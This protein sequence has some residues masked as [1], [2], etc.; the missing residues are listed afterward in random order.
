MR[1]LMLTTSASLMDGINRHILAISSGLQARGVEVC[2]C[3]VHSQ[4]DFIAALRNAGVEVCSLGCKNG[5]SLRIPLRFARV[6]N[7]F[8]PD[9]V[10]VHVLAFMERLVLSTLFSRVKVVQT[11]HGISDPVSSRTWRQ[12]VANLLERVFDVRI[13]R[14][15]FVSNGVRRAFGGGADND[16]TIYNPVGIHHS[17]RSTLRQELGVPDSVNIVG[18]ACRIASVKNPL[19]FT[20]VIREVTKRITGS[21]GVV[22]GD[23]DPVLMGELKKLVADSPNVHLLGYRTDAQQLIAGLD[24]FVMTSMREGMPTAVLEAMV[25]GVP[26]VFWKGEGGLVDLAELSASELAFGVAVDRGDE[27]AMIDAVCRTM[28]NGEKTEGES[29]VERFFS[30]SRITDQLM[31]LYG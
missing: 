22:I 26:I 29:V 17:G 11:I 28:R 31:E 5:H 4:G 19:A 9:V 8:N 20:R 10:H 15:A 7:D 2:V 6:M 30:V 18:T 12:R 21:H 14:R 25:A 24:C 27:R 23:G 13:A 3:V 1:V 16:L